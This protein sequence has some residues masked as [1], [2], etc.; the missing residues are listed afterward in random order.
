[1]RDKFA[2]VE[3]K[4]LIELCYGMPTSGE[5]LSAFLAKRPPKFTGGRGSSR[6]GSPECSQSSASGAS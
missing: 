3:D 1:M 6:C 5:G 4:D 2:G